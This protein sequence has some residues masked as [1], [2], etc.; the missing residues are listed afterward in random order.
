MQ[1]DFFNNPNK[2]TTRKSRFGL[3]DD[4]APVNCPTTCAYIDESDEEKWTAVVTNTNQ[5]TANFYPIDNCI[6]IRRPNGDMDNR[7]DGLLEYENNL[8]FVEL[9]DRCSRHGWVRD[10]L[11]Q[12]KVTIRNFTTYHNIDDFNSIK[13]QLCNKQHP[14]AVVSCKEY[15]EKFKDETGYKVSVDRN[16]TIG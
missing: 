14:A 5:K 13:A 2:A 7:C 1:V 15:V 3:C 12:L 6:E 16:I 4:V 11:N 10:G 8:I 9:K